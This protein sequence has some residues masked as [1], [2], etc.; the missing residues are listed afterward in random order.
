MVIHHFTE[1]GI[2]L[3]YILKNFFGDFCFSGRESFILSLI[4]DTPSFN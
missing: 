3:N 4:N 2:L 1:H